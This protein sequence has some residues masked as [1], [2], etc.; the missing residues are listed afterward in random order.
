[1]TSFRIRTDMSSS[2]TKMLA[3]LR[4][5]PLQWRGFK[6]IRSRILARLQIEYA[7]E[8]TSIAL[9]LSTS[10]GNRGVTFGDGGKL[11]LEVFSAVGAGATGGGVE[12][13]AADEGM[14]PR[15]SGLWQNPCAGECVDPM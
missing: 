6:S 3:V 11:W 12:A 8:V 13:R 15:D 2:W 1:M 14:R 9:V 5:C 10:R 4:C 7:V